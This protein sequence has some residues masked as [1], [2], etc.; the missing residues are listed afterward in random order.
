MGSI[1]VPLIEHYNVKEA[2]EEEE[3]G[4]L[5]IKDSLVNVQADDEMRVS[6]WI[7]RSRGGCWNAVKKCFGRFDE[8]LLTFL[9]R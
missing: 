5:N 2:A 8:C 1:M 4:T 9:V 7:K 3:E 6:Q